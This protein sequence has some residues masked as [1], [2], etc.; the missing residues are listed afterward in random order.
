[1]HR[2]P[3]AETNTECDTH[4][5]LGWEYTVPKRAT[6]QIVHTVVMTCC[7]FALHILKFTRGVR[8]LEY[9]MPRAGLVCAQ[10][11]S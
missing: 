7:H 10:D 6:A 11:W 3:Y 9:P 4:V 2:F 5:L 8:A 1:M